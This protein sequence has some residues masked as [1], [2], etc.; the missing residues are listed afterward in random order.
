MSRW[1]GVGCYVAYEVIEEQ[2]CVSTILGRFRGDLLDGTSKKLMC[3]AVVNL[4]PDTE[5]LI[6]GR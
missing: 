5:S 3:L 6:V 4:L 1:E 2:D